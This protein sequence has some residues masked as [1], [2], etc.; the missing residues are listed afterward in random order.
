MKRDNLYKDNEIDRLSPLHEVIACMQKAIKN[1]SPNEYVYADDEK[2]T[3]IHHEEI[4]III[5]HLKYGNEWSAIEYS[6]SFNYPVSIKEPV[7]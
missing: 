1:L 2:G 7:N 5:H 6:D 3:N 4:D